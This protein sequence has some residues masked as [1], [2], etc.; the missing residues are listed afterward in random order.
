MNGNIISKILIKLIES[1]ILLNPKNR[2]KLEDIVIPNQYIKAIICLTLNGF[3]TIPKKI[4]KTK[5]EI[6]KDVPKLKAEMI[7][8]TCNCININRSTA[9]IIPIIRIEIDLNN[10]LIFFVNTPT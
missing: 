7:G 2:A 8:Y 4:R 1:V 9:I 6:N 10:S 5:I 3:N